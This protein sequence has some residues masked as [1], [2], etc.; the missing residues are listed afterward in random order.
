MI[1]WLEL[2][3]VADLE[4]RLFIV[5]REGGVV[6]LARFAYCVHRDAIGSDGMENGKSSRESLI[7]RH[8]L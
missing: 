1:D 8:L 3:R 5:S 4:R 7:V 2:Y 6:G